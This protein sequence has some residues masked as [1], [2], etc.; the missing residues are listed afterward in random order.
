[1]NLRPL[2]P[3]L[4]ARGSP[5]SVLVPSPQVSRS[6]R[7]PVSAPVRRRP[8]RV[9]VPVAVLRRCTRWSEQR[10]LLDAWADCDGAAGS[11]PQLRLMPLTGPVLSGGRAPRRLLSL[12]R[13]LL[14]TRRYR[15]DRTGRDRQRGGLPAQPGLAP[16]DARPGRRAT[17]RPYLRPQT[18]GRAERFNRTWPTGGLHP[19]FDSSPDRATALPG[20]LHDYGSHR[21]QAAHGGQPPIS[22]TT[23]SNAAAHQNEPQR[24]ANRADTRFAACSATSTQS[25]RRLR[26]LTPM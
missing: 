24:Y 20:W 25:P 21:S 23:D 6:P 4:P 3:Q 22:R 12:G 13:G 16:C 17:L 18:N 7:P 2:D 19:P 11:T 5:P 15:P 10:D 9:A 26:P 14:R 8:G 1:L